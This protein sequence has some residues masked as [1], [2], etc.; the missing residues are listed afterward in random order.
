MYFQNER[1]TL[2]LIANVA[3]QDSSSHHGSVGEPIS[4]VDELETLAWHKS[5]VCIGDVFAMKYRDFTMEERNII[6]EFEK[7]Q[8]TSFNLNSVGYGGYDF[9]H[10]FPLP[11][12]LRTIRDS[13]RHEVG[14]LT[15]GDPNCSVD[16]TDAS[17]VYRHLQHLRKSFTGDWTS[18]FK[19]AY[20]EFGL[21]SVEN[22]PESR[23]N[24]ETLLVTQWLGADSSFKEWYY[25]LANW[26]IVATKES[27]KNPFGW[28][29]Y[30]VDIPEEV[31][32]TL[33]S[34]RQPGNCKGK[35]E[36]QKA[37][38]VKINKLE[39]INADLKNKLQQSKKKKGNGENQYESELKVSQQKIHDVQ[40]ELSGCRDD[41]LE[42]E[43]A[44]GE[45]RRRLSLKEAD[46]RALED[47]HREATTQ[48]RLDTAKIKSLEDRLGEY[49][50]EVAWYKNRQHPPPTP[51]GAHV[52]G[53]ASH[54]L[55]NIGS[56]TM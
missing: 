56:P 19:N 33:L 16:T 7:Q 31:T 17:A 23:R 11:A 15:L 50:E 37:L 32:E 29:R 12:H 3:V 51:L 8:A 6:D 26:Y 22:V 30:Y 45:Y 52:H 27:Q 40:S 41:L 43:G 35:R 10:E 20:A 42:A 13:L 14:K 36:N 34:Q 39:K 5:P 48:N 18:A 9:N 38:H 28:M 24:K 54:S 44:V 21:K 55:K 1:I 53:S 49:K 4:C 25:A 2:G 47:K 46:M